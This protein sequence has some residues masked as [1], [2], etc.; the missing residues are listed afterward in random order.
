MSFR[1]IA[2]LVALFLCF[3]AHAGLVSARRLLASRDYAGAHVACLDEA[4][5]GDPWCR[6]ILGFL[7]QHGAGVETDKAA[8]LAWF[9]AAAEQG[10][11]GGQWV[12]ARRYYKG[13][14]VARDYAKAGGHSGAQFSIGRMYEGGKGVEVNAEEAEKWFRKAARQGHVGAH[15]E[16]GIVRGVTEEVKLPG[17]RLE[18]R[19]A[20]AAKFD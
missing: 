19:E 14:L 17:W 11:P 1:A 20:L 18:L 3:P 6:I 10:H 9:K 4:R 15:H 16:L 2:A 8:A 7:R 13:R 12:L 5:S